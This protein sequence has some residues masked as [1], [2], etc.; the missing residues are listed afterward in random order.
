[1]ISA[2]GRRPVMAAPMVAPTIACSLMGVSQTRCGPNSANS[3]TVVLKTPSAAPMSSPRH[4][5]VGSLRI[6][7]AMPLATASR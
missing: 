3:P 6:S 5:T 4:T 2:T 7:C 1:M